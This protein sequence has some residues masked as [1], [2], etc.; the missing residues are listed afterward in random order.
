MISVQSRGCVFILTPSLVSH[1]L[2][3][4]A[5]EASV[6][7]ATGDHG[8]PSHFQPA[9]L[10]SFFGRALADVVKDTGRLAGTVIY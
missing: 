7:T 1:G 2:A 4:T 9:D 3:G 10:M 5:V 8:D 6:Y